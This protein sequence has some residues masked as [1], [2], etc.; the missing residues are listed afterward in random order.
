MDTKQTIQASEVGMYQVHGN[1]FD[2]LMDAKVFFEEFFQKIVPES[3]LKES[4]TTEVI[5]QRGASPV[6]AGVVSLLYGEDD[7]GL[8]FLV[9][10]HKETGKLLHMSTY[11]FYLAKKMRVMV[12]TV[13]V[14]DDL[15]E[16]TVRCRIGEFEFSFFAVDYFA[17]KE[18][19][20]PG[21]EIEIR[22]GA[23]GMSHKEPQFSLSIE[24]QEAVDWLAKFGSFFGLE[25]E[26][27]ENGQVKPVRIDLEQFVGFFQSDDK[28]PDE[29]S[30]QS[31]AGEIRERSF[32]G[33]D[34]YE[35]EIFIHRLYDDSISIPLIIKKEWM[36][37]AKEGSP[38]SGTLWVAGAF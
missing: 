30:F 3:K 22:V 21:K 37:E 7:L 12:D 14:W 11:P 38:L 2:A 15:L 32:L 6:N 16:A 28:C 5:L 13:W 31:P 35:T 18:D 10:V 24:G 36:P 20:V 8:L 25:V 29:A 4:A 9:A 33:I 34:F 23:M 26:Y 1:H 27:D 19:Y 17:H